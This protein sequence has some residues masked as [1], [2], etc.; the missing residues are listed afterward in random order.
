MWNLYLTENQLGRRGM[1]CVVDN[2]NYIIMSN[3]YVQQKDF[4]IRTLIN[5]CFK[6]SQLSNMIF[7]G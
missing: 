2:H 4:L 3:N 5:I 6:G 7:I 1:L